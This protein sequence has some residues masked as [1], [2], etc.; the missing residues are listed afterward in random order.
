M[1][2]VTSVDLNNPDKQQM[3]LETRLLQLD[4]AIQME[5]WQEAFK[6]IDDVH[7]LVTLAKKMSRPQQM[8]Q[9]YQKSALVFGKS[10]NR[11]FHAAALFR[12]SS[13]SRD[14]KS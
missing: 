7:G 3:N 11:L 12:L 4:Y 9:Y 8:A 1:V 13:L 2:T 14:L 10:G 5:L 6:A